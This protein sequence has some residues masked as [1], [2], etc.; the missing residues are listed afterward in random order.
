VAAMRIFNVG[1]LIAD[2]SVVYPDTKVTVEGTYGKSP[3]YPHS[4][5]GYHEDLA[6]APSN[7][8]IT[9]REFL[10][11]IGSALGPMDGHKGGEYDVNMRT[12][13]WIAEHSKLG[14]KI[15]DTHFDDETNTLSLIVDEE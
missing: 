13:V 2:L 4:Y 15:M 1:A 12:T 3:S 6:F 11:L 7:D 10:V 8:T 9:A 14:S 5:R